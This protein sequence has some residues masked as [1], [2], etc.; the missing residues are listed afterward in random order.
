MTVEASVTFFAFGLAI[1]FLGGAALLPALR[2]MQ[3]RQHAYEDAPQTHQKKSGTPTMGGILFA[4]A[5][6]PLAISYR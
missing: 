4:F 3:F 5:M 6:F 1:V 2:A